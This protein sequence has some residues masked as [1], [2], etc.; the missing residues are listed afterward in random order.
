ML[1]TKNMN[2]SRWCTFAR[3]YGSSI[4]RVVGGSNSARRKTHLWPKMVQA[5]DTFF[6][7]L[8]F[9]PLQCWINK[10]KPAR[11]SMFPVRRNIFMLCFSLCFVSRFDQTQRGGG[12]E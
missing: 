8:V 3:I 7:S 2:C 6:V 5:L 12:G 11:R 9:I 1:D 4:E 10:K